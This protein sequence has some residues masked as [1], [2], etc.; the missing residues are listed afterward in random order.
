MSGALEVDIRI[1]FVGRHA[2]ALRALH[3]LTIRIPHDR[4]VIVGGNWC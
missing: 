2:A 3:R 1:D 4:W